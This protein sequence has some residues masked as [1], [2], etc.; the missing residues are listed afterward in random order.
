[1][2]T[3]TVGVIP[4]RHPGC[5]NQEA[6]LRQGARM[7][8]RNYRLSIVCRSCGF[9]DRPQA[10][11]DAAASNPMQSQPE[12]R[13]Y[14]GRYPVAA[15]LEWL[16]SDQQGNVEV[17]QIESEQ[18]EKKQEVV[19]VQEIEVAPK[20]APVELV[21]GQVSEVDGVMA[22]DGLFYGLPKPG[23][24]PGKADQKQRVVIDNE[25]GVL[26]M[27][28]PAVSEVKP[29]LSPSA[30]RSGGIGLGGWM[31][32]IGGGLLVGLGL[33]GGVKW[34]KKTL[35][36]KL[37]KTAADTPLTGTNTGQMET[38][39]EAVKETDGKMPS[40]WKNNLNW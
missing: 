7:S 29:E 6:E 37:T 2:S 17:L 4:C 19:T 26:D 16:E 25:A 12:L 5:D 24:R 18:P 40:D 34:L 22:E 31:L 20:I 27:D 33:W 21:K 30:D 10:M 23:N 11:T 13:R 9:P 14:V 35:K 39:V 38:V 15:K 32:R 28:E 8:D 36:A 1:M 3:Q